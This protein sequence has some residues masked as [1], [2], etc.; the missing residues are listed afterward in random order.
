[1]KKGVRVAAFLFCVVLQLGCALGNGGQE[2]LTTCAAL[3]PVDAKAELATAY[4]DW[5]ILEHDHLYPH[6]QEIWGPACPGLAAGEF[7]GSGEET[8]AV[9]IVRQV[10]QTKQ[11]KLLLLEKTNATYTIRVLREEE[12]VP[13]YPVVHREPPGIYRYFYDRQNTID[14]LHDVFVYE[15]LEATATVFYYKDGEYQQ[16][17]ISD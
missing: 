3:L 12:E 14:A 8:Y 11:A 16:L 9:L 5:V 4:E 15:H 7:D 17:L 10:A 2:E 1:M 6:Q 13:S